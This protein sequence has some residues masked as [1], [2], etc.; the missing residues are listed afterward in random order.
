MIMGA[1]YRGRK[2]FAR[3]ICDL[4]CQFRS[5]NPPPGPQS[6]GASESI[7]RV[8]QDKKTLH[9]VVTKIPFRSQIAIGSPHGDHRMAWRRSEKRG[10]LPPRQEKLKEN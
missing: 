3:P 5:A 1:S 10:R 9:C 8:F 4:A 7:L 2:L 6:A